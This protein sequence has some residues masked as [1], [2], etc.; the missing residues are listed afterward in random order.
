MNNQINKIGFIGLG[1]MGFHMATH[2]ANKYKQLNVY[3][4]SFDKTELWIKQF[5]NTDVN[6]NGYKNLEE[7][8]K[9][10]NTIILCIGNDDSVRNTVNTILPYL[11][12]N[13]IIIDHTTTSANLAQEMNALCLNSEIHFL[14]CPVSGGEI[15][16]KNGAL[17]I[18]A[19]GNKDIFNKILDILK[20]YSKCQSYFGKSGSG[21]ITKMV[22]QILIAN[23]LQGLSEGLNLAKNSN[24]DIELLVNTLKMGAAGSWQ[25]ENRGITMCN[26][27]FNFGFAIDLMLKDLNIVEE[28]AMQKNLNITQTKN[29]KNIYQELS[30]LGFGNSDT[31]ALIKQFKD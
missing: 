19:G 5:E 30:Q 6:I 28:F 24:L 14:D 22:N 7:F 26:N 23:V 18:M 4:R 3:N 31:S 13:N 20:C 10:S 16:A 29:I 15:G 21:Q 25:L 27:Q 11:N 2:L 9:N 12:K 17:T 1:K 8:S